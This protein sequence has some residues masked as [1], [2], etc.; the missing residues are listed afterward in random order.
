MRCWSAASGPTEGPFRPVDVHTDSNK[1][2]KTNVRACRTVTQRAFGW[3]SSIQRRL[4]R[5][6]YSGL[7]KCHFVCAE[8]S[9]T[10]TCRM[11]QYLTLVANWSRYRTQIHILPRC[12]AATFEP[13][14]AESC[15]VF[16]GRRV[17]TRCA[18]IPP[19]FDFRRQHLPRV[20]LPFRL[21]CHP[22]PVTYNLPWLSFKSFLRQSLRLPC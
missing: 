11:L 15:L 9:D 20:F 22:I 12:F 1:A 8:N 5:G 19:N 6:A 7:P 10:E 16:T 21:P 18:S 13:R 3:R 4:G 17:F 14:T 2:G